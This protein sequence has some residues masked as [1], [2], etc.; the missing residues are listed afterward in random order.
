MRNCN[1]VDAHSLS[2]DTTPYPATHQRGSAKI[3]FVLV[4]P[5]VVSAVTGVFTF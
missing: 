5:R 1:L 2:S 4:S 3:D